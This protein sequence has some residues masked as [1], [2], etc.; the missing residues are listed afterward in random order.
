MHTVAAICSCRKRQRIDNAARRAAEWCPETVAATLP[1]TQTQPGDGDQARK[2]EQEVALARARLLVAETAA[3]RT[4]WQRYVEEVLTPLVCR[5]PPPPVAAVGHVAEAAVAAYDALKREGLLTPRDRRAK[6]A[7]RGLLL[8][9]ACHEGW[10]KHGFLAFRASAYSPHWVAIGCRIVEAGVAPGAEAA[11]RIRT[12]P[13]CC[14]VPA[15][16]TYCHDIAGRFVSHTDQQACF[17]LL[18]AQAMAAACGADVASVAQHLQRRKYTNTVE[19]SALAANTDLLERVAAALYTHVDAA[20]ATPLL[21]LACL[22]G[23][24]DMDA[25]WNASEMIQ[26]LQAK[27]AAA[28]GV[29]LYAPHAE[30]GAVFTDPCELDYDETDA[31]SV[32]L[33]EARFWTWLWR[34]LQQGAP[35]RPLTE[36]PDA[37][38][39]ERACMLLERPPFP[40]DAAAKAAAL[41][42][43]KRL[44]P[45]VQGVRPQKE[46]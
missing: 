34:T 33:Q 31:Q 10:T 36:R 29:R 30:D 42:Q 43:A 19:R 2:Q 13:A 28:T 23:R 7:P 5:E 11:A 37:A 39:L 12:L 24:M 32:V 1:Q 21:A 35:A 9:V 6:H 46:A 18:L 44:L 4:P 38:T 8:A 15:V 25:W 14:D 17:P 22:V 20:R 41:Q 3:A 40:G 26:D 16:D 45:G 27:C